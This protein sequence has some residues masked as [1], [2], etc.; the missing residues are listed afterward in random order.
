[1]AIDAPIV[2]LDYSPDGRTVAV[3]TA[4][5]AENLLLLD[6]Q[7]GAQVASY[8]LPTP[9]VTALDFS[10]DGRLLAV[11][12]AQG[13]FTIWDSQRHIQLTSGAT[14]A[15]IHDISFSPDGTLLAVSI[16]KY[17]LLL[18]GVPLGSG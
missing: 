8:P 10:P 14:E 15:G 12:A 11:G 17:A 2:A 16:D 18:Y 5:R 7:T 6:A 3:A 9:G 1:M 13:L 4:R